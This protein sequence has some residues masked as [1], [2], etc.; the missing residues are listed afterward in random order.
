MEWLQKQAHADR[1]RLL[2]LKL[3]GDMLDSEVRMPQRLLPVMTVVIYR[4]VFF[5]YDNFLHLITYILA[6]AAVHMYL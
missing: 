6:G 3:P 5:F 2:E 4:A 1:S